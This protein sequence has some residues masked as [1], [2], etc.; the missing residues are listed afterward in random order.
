MVYSLILSLLTL[1]IVILSI[2]KIRR[3][4]I[5]SIC[6]LILYLLSFLI[7]IVDPTYYLE[8]TNLINNS[9]SSDISD[10]LFTYSF[11]VFLISIFEFTLFYLVRL[12]CKYKNKEGRVNNEK[13]RL[14][15]IDAICKRVDSLDEEIIVVLN[16]NSFYL[17]NKLSNHYNL[18]QNLDFK[19]MSKYI[20][21]SSD[22][23][24]KIKNFKMK[25]NDE[26]INFEKSSIISLDS[27]F[28]I[29]KKVKLFDFVLNDFN[30]FLN[31]LN[32]NKNIGV[33]AFHIS[34]IYK[35]LDSVYQ[36]ES[37][38]NL[39]LTLSKK[40]I[41]SLM[42]FLDDACTCCYKIDINEYAFIINDIKIFKF[43]IEKIKINPNTLDDFVYFIN[44]NKYI[45][46]TKA[47]L[48]TGSNNIE[49]L[50][51]HMEEILLCDKASS[52]YCDDIDD[53]IKNEKSEK[54]EKLEVVNV[55][56]MNVNID[57]DILY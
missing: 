4:L 42:R 12:I 43:L 1:F 6:L 47:V 52:L 23:F 50:A 17:N 11:V 10:F 5:I 38:E 2:V 55:N 35:D 57:K 24:K 53:I 56:R 31:D 45:I 22:S 46:K 25:L 15:E 29:F 48:M 3:V 20:D 19:E 44:D 41:N 28:V 32:E 13:I 14:N 26:I 9:D 21:I 36:V 18:S 37:D 39:R 16:D 7:K 33:F 54:L 40:Y 34:S 8:L 49:D 30:T 51:K 27:C